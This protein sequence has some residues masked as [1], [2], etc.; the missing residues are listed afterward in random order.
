M[1]FLVI[2]K[3]APT[4]PSDA[5]SNRQQFWVWAREKMDQGVITGQPYAKT[6]R[7]AIAIFDVESNE[8]LHRLLSEWL[9]LIP[10]E[11]EIHPLVDPDATAKFLS[12]TPS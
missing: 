1:L 10:A 4:R 11:F 3:P 9:E 12:E 6:G 8:A 5:R 7:G 2:S